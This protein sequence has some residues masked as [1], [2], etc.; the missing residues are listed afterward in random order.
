MCFVSKMLA[1]IA[2]EWSC[3]R[4]L[5]LLFFFLQASRAVSQQSF[6]CARFMFVGTRNH[7][8]TIQAGRSRKNIFRNHVVYGFNGQDE[9][10]AIKKEEGGGKRMKGKEHTLS[11]DRQNG[12]FEKQG[13]FTAA[14][15]ERCPPSKRSVRG[16]AILA[17]TSSVLASL[18]SRFDSIAKFL[19]V[20]DRAKIRRIMKSRPKGITTVRF[21]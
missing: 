10:L 16:I 9:W 20:N 12:P 2:H 4:F 13:S 15:A 17:F 5:F 6:M 7:K 3:Y 14:W 19:S 8:I 11:T 18:S 21:K 1:K